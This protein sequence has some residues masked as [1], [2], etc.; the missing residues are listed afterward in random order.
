[1]RPLVFT[2]VQK[3]YVQERPFM[4]LTVCCRFLI[5]SVWGEGGESEGRSEG[6][7]SEGENK[8]GGGA[9]QGV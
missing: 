1:M 4:H 2:V 8:R 6:A 7:E 5:S 3:F 9:G